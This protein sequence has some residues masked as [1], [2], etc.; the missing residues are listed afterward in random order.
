MSR[1][2]V[3]SGVD[4]HTGFKTHFLD[5]TELTV[6]VVSLALQLLNPLPFP[7]NLG[8]GSGVAHLREDM[9]F[10]YPASP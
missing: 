5:L 1:S 8:A 4:G 10:P 7:I 3:G 2:A 9:T 6:P